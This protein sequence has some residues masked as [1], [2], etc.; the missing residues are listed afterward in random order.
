MRL[1]CLQPDGWYLASVTDEITKKMNPKLLLWILCL[2]AC[3]EGMAQSDLFTISESNVPLKKIIRIIENGKKYSF[4]YRKEFLQH[5]GRVT[6][7]VE[8]KPIREVMSQA[9]R[10]LFLDYVLIGDSIVVLKP[11]GSAFQQTTSLISVKGKVLSETGLPLEGVSV[12]VWNAAQGTFTNE[13][14]EFALAGIQPE[15]VLLF[16]YLGYQPEYLSIKGRGK[17]E[18]KLK[19]AAVKSMDETIIIGYG[20]TSKRFNTGSVYKISAGEIR[21]QPVAN[22]LATLQSNV[23]GL[24]VTQNSG[25]PGTAFKV[26]L[27]GQNSIGITPGELPPN[28]PFFIIDGVPFGPNNNSLQTIAS[29]TALGAKGRSP[30]ALINPSDIESI[31]V[32]KDA[33]ATAIYGSRGANGVV[34]ITTKKGKPGKA[35]VNANVYSGISNITRHIDMLNTAQYVQM[36]FKAL[37]NDGLIPD[38]DN[39]ADLLVWDTANYTDFKKM[40]IGKTAGITNIQLSLNG[41]SKRFYYLIGT[42]YNHETTVFPGNLS[43]NRA[44]LHMHV[45]HQGGKRFS[46]GL[47]LLYAVDKNNSIIKDLTEFLTLPPN[48]PALF[49]ATGNLNWQHEGKAFINPVSFLKQPYEARTG[50]LITGLDLNFRVNANLVL[51]ANWGYNYLAADEIALV[52][53]SAQ[54]TFL[55]PGIQGRSYFS[56]NVYKN[57]IAEPQAE[58]TA[59]LKHS[60]LTILAGGT[61]QR[62]LNNARGIVATGFENDTFLRNVHEAANLDTQDLNTEYRYAAVFARL[63]YILHDTYVVN[64]TARRDGSSR[65]GPSK[66]FGN[67]GAAGVAWIF[68]N[69]SFIHKNLPFISFGKLRGSYGVTGSDQIG[70]YK[71]L[72]RWTIVPNNYLGSNGIVPM[73]LADN[74]YS[75]EV[76]HK[77]EMAMEL[78]LLK[79]L[80]QLSVAYYRNRNS[81]QLI[82]YPLPAVTGFTKYEA[83]NSAAVVQNSGVEILFRAQSKPGKRLEWTNGISL[84][85]PKNKLLFFPRLESSAYANQLI[86][87]QS[88]SVRQGFQYTGIDPGSGLFR[89]RD[90][91][92]DGIIN[93]PGDYRVLGNLDPE[94]YAGIQNSLHYKQWH[95][96][97]L[98]EIRKQL[99]LNHQYSIYILSPPGRA[100][101]NQ[102]KD[103]FGGTYQLFSTGANDNAG[104]AGNNFINSDGVLS[105]AS[106][107]RMKNISLSWTLP[108]KWQEKLSLSNCRIYML[109]QNLITITRY[110][111]VDPE[112][113]NIRTLP[114]L[115]TIAGGIELSF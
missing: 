105:D 80:V 89:F 26:Q 84:T 82:A 101:Y 33:D 11:S 87:G 63:H 108:V 14:G 75:W 57:L 67:F 99:A 56:N 110:Y 78:G 97:V 77:L 21:R 45:K 31:E 53:R 94:W 5:A 43:N 70:D 28:D 44:S 103:L 40:L 24:L 74:N 4:A 95:L 42:G 27:R 50:N 3:G 65:F 93:Y 41:G 29:G 113:Q 38:N 22:P 102:P 30:L 35:L 91:N 46:A 6:V 76:S 112:T 2:V 37:Q 60:K 111:G 9:L 86:T 55:F 19:I 18:L 68:S 36:R 10:D 71:Y 15:A 49:D 8:N 59:Y 61:L 7:H 48:T 16:S 85:I 107:I 64:L 39:A 109:A 72:D 54:N 23:P 114:P 20:Q 81:N 88:L 69:E 96:D 17:I 79:D 104:T 32:L 106:Y 62:T 1:V 83:R 47:S 66:Q 115:K 51:K 12:W 58:Y 25:L 100:M 52:P 90:L 73:Q 34:L 13:S 98:W 92:D